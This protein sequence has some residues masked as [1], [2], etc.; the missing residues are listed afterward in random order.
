MAKML[1]PLMVII[2][3]S[4]LIHPTNSDPRIG[5]LNKKCGSNHAKNISTF[6]QNYLKLM[7][8]LQVNMQKNKF[9][10]GQ[11]GKWPNR[12]YVLAQCLDDLSAT[13]CQ[14]CFAK[15]SSQVPGC[16][17]A[18]SAI[19]YLEGCFIRVENYSFYKEYSWADDIQRCSDDLDR[20][21]QFA[22]TAKTVVH[23]LVKK[24][25]GN[26]GY[27]D[28]HATSDGLSVYG[29][30]K[31][32]QN[33]DDEKCAAC[34]RL[35]LK[36]ALDCL[37]G[38]EGRALKVGCFLRF[39]DYDFLNRHH[40]L[41]NTGAIFLYVACVLGAAG[42]CSSAIVIGYFVG[43]TIYNRRITRHDE[44]KGSAMESFL[45]KRSLQFKYSMLEKAT[46]NFI[47]AHKIGQGGF[48]EVFKGTLPDGREI[49]IKRLGY[50]APEY[51]AEGR[52]TDKVDVYSYGVLV[53]EIVSG[54]QN[55]NFQS[56]DS[57]STLVTSMHLSASQSQTWLIIITT[58]INLFPHSH[59]DPRIS[60]AGLFCG[61]TRPPPNT[62]YIPTFVKEME[63][64]SQQVT[65]HQWGQ[66][67]VNSTPPIYGLAQCYQD[68]SPTD[69]LLCY[70]ASRTRVPRCLPFISARLY[71]D[72]C[73]LRY[74]HYNFFNETIDP[75]QDTVNCSSTSLGMDVNDRGRSELEKNVGV[76]IGNMTERA[77]SNDGF[78]VMEVK[79]VFGLAQCWKTLSADGCRE[80]LQKAGKGVKGCLPSR[81]G[82]GL[83]AGCYMRYSTRK[84]FNDEARNK[85]DRSGVSTK[86]AIIA[87]VLVGVAFLMFSLFAVYAAYIQFSKLP[88]DRYNPG[89]ISNS[90]NKYNSLNFKYE[91][92]EKATNYF[93]LSRKIGQ[94]GAGSVYK[95]DLPNGSTVA[96]KRLFFNTRQWVDEFFNEVNLISGIQHN[97]LVK[98]LGCSIEGP[99][100]L[101]VYEYIPN[102]SLDQFL[103]DKNKVQILN[104]KQR[105]DII[106]GTADGLAYLHGGSETRIIHRDIKSSNVLLD[107]K[108]APKIADFGLVRCFGDDKTH[109]ST[110]IA[111]TLGYMAPEYLVRGQLTEKAD[112]YSFGVLVL[113][114]VC[115]RK[116]NVFIED[117]GS[118]LQTV[119]KLY[120]MDKLAELV[121]PCLN[122]D[123]PE[124]EASFVLEIG[125]LCTQA[126]ASL[127]PSMTR[128][129][130]MLKNRDCEI[131]MPNQPPFLSSR[132]RDP[133]NSARYYSINSLV[134]NALTKMEVSY[135]STE[136]STIQSSD[137]P[138]RSGEFEK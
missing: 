128:V 30:A 67:L 138:S 2:F 69:C 25:P 81:E 32:W 52:L 53:L 131:P 58:L 98:L 6:N 121:D 46:E 91:T 7:Q 48:G 114:I 23:E 126:S 34:L 93:D 101:L 116:N 127:R 61:T 16:F 17:P 132:L 5:T 102:K 73:F 86:G 22:K 31:C 13:E 47:E 125:L 44:L 4:C 120:K 133:A 85:E 87:I 109:L 49:A 63:Y 110:G 3:I 103:F 12:A 96:V 28:G 29:M 76:L 65:N 107:D 42:I 72:G 45:V 108:L 130:Q 8:S 51:L 56:E 77:V 15:L 37:P 111:G 36:D 54:M 119:W 43:T 97:N 84:F 129:V 71:F 33:L 136:S 68:L 99:E 35:A 74:D 79:G 62:S 70:A 94:G 40:P 27:A 80:C 26:E 89:Q 104:W 112:V 137:G 124:Q 88:A 20:S 105:F 9:A 59:S 1:F 95:G 55:N 60:E 14:I 135:T 78:A 117:S 83:N 11:K 118:L 10:R 64:L 57:L 50:M 134:S 18:T 82:K 21:E 122:G 123:F 90:F 100:S 19:V 66:H 39:S 106:V 41:S 92:L 75:N 24:A 113:E 38:V 115:G